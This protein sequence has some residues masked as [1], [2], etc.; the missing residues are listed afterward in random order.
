MKTNKII[1]HHQ[2]TPVNLLKDNEKGSIK[3][4][5]VKHSIA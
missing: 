3:K 5:S 1:A 4:E 2:V